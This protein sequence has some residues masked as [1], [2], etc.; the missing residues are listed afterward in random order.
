MSSNV[1]H[2]RNLLFHFCQLWAVKKY[3]NFIF[4]YCYRNLKY[5]LQ[6]KTIIFQSYSALLVTHFNFKVTLKF[7]HGFFTSWFGGSCSTYS[8]RIIDKQ[9]CI[10]KGWAILW[11]PIK[12]TIPTWNSLHTNT[13][14]LISIIHVLKACSKVS[15][16][17]R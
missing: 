6:G 10:G 14:D 9:I 17:P 4:F 12:F 7:C 8:L 16:Q 5:Y 15:T 13:S 1:R 11:N 2:V 3:H